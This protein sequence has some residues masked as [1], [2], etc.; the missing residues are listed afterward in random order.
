M[1]GSNRF[2]HCRKILLSAFLLATC[3]NQW[4]DCCQDQVLARTV[5]KSFEDPL[6]SISKLP[7]DQRGGQAYKLVYQINTPIQSY[8]RFKTDFN[9]D[10]V[11]T[12]RYIRSHKV[13]LMAQDYVITENRYENSPD[14]LFRWRT[15]VDQARYQMNFKL[16]NPKECKQHF[17]Y[18]QIHLESIPDG[19]R[20]IQVAYFDFFGASLWALYPWKGGLKDFLTS[21]VLWEQKTFMQLKDRYIKKDKVP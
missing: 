10:F 3:S 20:V 1:Q 6:I 8:W 4:F 17:H 15:S 11:V 2:H 7:P 13:L 18:G 19:T 16:L 21:T 12:N 14:L 9:N 5:N